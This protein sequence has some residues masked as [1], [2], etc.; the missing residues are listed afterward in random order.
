MLGGIEPRS[1]LAIIGSLIRQSV[2]DLK[3]DRHLVPLT[4][5]KGADSPVSFQTEP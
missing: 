1:F 3:P 2:G 4:V 5:G